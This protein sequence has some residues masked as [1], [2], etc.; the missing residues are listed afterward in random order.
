M[1][2]GERLLFFILLSG[3]F[4]LALTI[5]GALPS[6]LV[7]V[8]GLLGLLLVL[9]GP[10]YSLQMALFPHRRE[11]DGVERLALSIG[12]SLGCIPIVA[13]LLDQLPWGL[14]LETVILAELGI[15][16]SGAVVGWARRRRLPPEPRSGSIPNRPGGR[17]LFRVYG[18]LAVALAAVALL[19]LRTSGLGESATE[20]YIVD[21]AG[22]ARAYPYKVGVG[23]PVTVTVG[24]VNHE[25]VPMEY[26]LEVV[27]G[28]HLL[29]EL[30]PVRLGPGATYE[31]PLTFTPVRAGDHLQ[32]EFLLYW[33][34]FPVP[35][36]TLWLWLEVTE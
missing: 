6:P 30:G 10:G 24:V 11:L 34:G 36:R 32:V 27:D 9:L 21:S 19:L 1:I 22:R 17:N 31:G 18:G 14:R 29:G 20:F 15:T 26:R 2:R 7:A 33:S 23:E 4:L 12:I 35:C 28:E 3:L 25:E 8:R 16:A 5:P 13:L